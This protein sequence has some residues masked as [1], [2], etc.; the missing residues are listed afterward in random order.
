[1]EEM[2]QASRQLLGFIRQSDAPEKAMVFQPGGLSFKSC[3]V[4]FKMCHSGKVFLTVQHLFLHF[5]FNGT[6]NTSL[7]K[8]LCKYTISYVMLRIPLGHSVSAVQIL[9][10]PSPHNIPEIV[11]SQTPPVP[12]VTD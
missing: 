10:R 9:T 6:N 12:K 8:L 7:S 5:F 4:H 2:R 3:L 1:M 11:P